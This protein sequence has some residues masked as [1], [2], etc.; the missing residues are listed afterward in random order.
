[1]VFGKKNKNEIQYY[2]DQIDRLKEEN[3]SLNDLIAD[4]KTELQHYKAFFNSNS[5]LLEASNRMNVAC[6]DIQD[7][8]DNLIDHAEAINFPD[9][10]ADV[11]PSVNDLPSETSNDA[12]V[13]VAA[14]EDSN[15]TIIDAK[16]N[17]TSDMDVIKD[18]FSGFFDDDNFLDDVSLKS[19]ETENIENT[20]Q[21]SVLPK[22][23]I[24]V[25]ENNHIYGGSNIRHE[26]N[27]NLLKHGGNIGYLIRPSERGKG[28]AK[29]MLKLTLKKCKELDISKVL[30]T[31][32][33]ENIASSNSIIISRPLSFYLLRI[34]FFLH[35]HM[36]QGLL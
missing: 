16:Q 36:F 5:K 3:A 28:F 25:D 4:Q 19:N 23:Q 33:E 35:F 17:A 20:V 31:C 27:N 11:S 29:L 34:Q 22:D 24:L 9:Q 14:P 18:S 12:I 1:M 21:E 15:N 30:L 13:D 2:V 10:N 6:G 8:F 26:L 32:R 7:A